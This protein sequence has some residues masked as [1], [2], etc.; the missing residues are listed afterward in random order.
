MSSDEISSLKRK[1]LSASDEVACIVGQ[2]RLAVKEPNKINSFMGMFKVLEKYYSIFE[3]AYDRLLGLADSSKSD[4][5]FPSTEE[6]ALKDNTRRYYYEANAIHYKLSSSE[7]AALQTS[8]QNVTISSDLNA[9][10]NDLPKIPLPKFDGQILNWPKFRD[11]FTSLVHNN[12]RITS[13]KKFFYLTSSL[14]GEA[15]SVLKHIPLEDKNY[16]LAWRT[17]T[18]AFENPRLIGAAYLNQILAF[19]PIQGKPTIE[20]IKT[21]LAKI[22]DNVAAF[23]LL[24]IEDETSFILLHLA[25]RCLDPTTRDQFE[26]AHKHEPFPTF[27]QLSKYLRERCLT[28]QLAD[29]ANVKFEESSSKSSFVKFNK[30]SPKSTLLASSD[31]SNSQ[32]SKPHFMQK[33][34]VV[35]HEGSHPL[36][37]CKKFVRSSVEQRLDFL[38]NWKGC[39]NCLSTTHQ[40]SHCS[41]KWSCRWC[42]AKHHSYLCKSLN[43]VDR[44]TSSNFCVEDDQINS[45][46][47]ERPSPSTSTSVCTHLSR[48][49]EMILG[50]IIAEIKDAR[51]IFQ[52]VRMVLDSGSHCSFLTQKCLRRLG[53]RITPSSVKVSSIG[54][55]Q[56]DGVKGEVFCDIRPVN[57]TQPILSTKALV[58]QNITNALPTIPVPS[59]I[60]KKYSQYPLA[61]PKFYETSPVEFLIGVDLFTD[62]W[63]GNAV[64]IDRQLPKLFPTVFGHVVMGS[65]SDNSPNVKVVPTLFTVTQDDDLTKGIAKFWEIEELPT[66][67][68]TNPDDQ[69]CEDHFINTHQRL[70]DGSYMVSLPFISSP[71]D[72]SSVSALSLRRFYNLETKFQRNPI[73]RNL[74]LE[75]MTDY[76]NLG[77]M[78]ITDDMPKYVIPH[79]S[80]LKEDRNKTKLRVVFDA[81]ARA[82]HGSLNDYLMTGP[83][84]QTD[85]R[86]VLLN[87]RSHK[88]VFVTDFVKMYRCIWVDP[89][90]RPYQCIYWR[91]SPDKS[92]DTYQCN[93][94][95]YGLTSSPYLAL[96]TVKQLCVDEGEAFPEAVRVLLRDTYIDDVA[97]GTNSLSD[98]IKLRDDLI[99]L[100]AKGNFTLSKWASNHP[101]LLEKIESSDKNEDPVSL[102]SK[103]DTTLKILGLQWNPDI[104]CFTYKFEP[105]RPVFTKRAILSNIA[106]IYDPLGFLS[107]FVITMKMIMQELWKLRIGWDQHIPDNLSKLWQS[108]ISDINI[109][110]TL[111]IPRYVFT[112]SKHQ[113]QIIG[114]SDAS[115]KAYCAAIYLKVI[116]STNTFTNLLV[117]KTKLAPLKTLSVPRLELLGALLLSK[118][119]SSIQPFIQILGNERLEDIFYTDSTIVLGWLATPPYLLKTFIANRVLEITNIIPYSLWC[120]VCT[121]HNP[122]DLGTRGLTPHQLINNQLWWT[123]P[124]WML[125]PASSWPRSV[126]PTPTDELPELKPVLC[127]TASN[128]T[129]SSFILAFIERFSSYPRLLRT[130]A[131]IKRLFYN[132]RKSNSPHV[133]PIQLCEIED[134]LIIFIKAVQLHYFFKGNFD[135]Q[136]PTMKRFLKLNPFLDNA[137]VLRAGGRLYHAQLPFNHKHPVLLPPDCHLSTLIVDH[138]HRIHLHPGPSL[139]QAIIQTEFWIPS[140]RRLV[141]KRIFMCV[142]CYKFRAKTLIPKMGDL[143][144]QRL[145]GERAFL[146]VGIDFA[147]PFSMK[148]SS[149]RNS[150]I[151]KAY[152]CLFICMASKALHLEAVSSLSTSAFLSTLDRFTAR[153]GVPADIYTD[154]G[155]TFI[156]ASKH[157]KELWEWFQKTSTQSEILDHCTVRH[158]HWHFNPPLASHFGGLWEA[159]VKSAKIYLKKAVG[160]SALTYEEFST[161]L[162]Q[163]EAILNSRPLCPL[164]SDP[165]EC[166]YLSP[167]HFLIG[168][169]L[170]SIPE[171]SLLDERLNTL[172]RWQLVKRMIEFFWR[173]WRI[174]YLSSLQSR[175]KW[176]KSSPSLTIGDLALLKDPNTPLMN[177]PMGR[178][179]EVHPGHDGVVRVVTIKTSKNTYKRP[180]TKLIPLIPANSPPMMAQ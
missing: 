140:L 152:M 115:E 12:D 177:W 155:T 15:E 5:T 123:G 13:I 38:K 17:L 87:F 31:S 69:I 168:E 131:R 26:V 171:P 82:D 64:S 61:D 129:R 92:V 81:S 154:C 138:F 101:K 50:T 71:P 63:R 90:D 109:L 94:V 151:S 146:R 173:R 107:P 103:E 106:K 125:F 32:S 176:N 96:R 19:K 144:S 148:F 65:F 95:T 180:V 79:H 80:I 120:H 117:A 104:D 108:L 53:L 160:D 121:D 67:S 156:A 22:C 77:H 56:F 158:I 75:F 88:W 55:S 111:R 1:L 85:I 41:S 25:L 165:A 7:P 3:E 114:F 44:P 157:L 139:L 135:N 175:V 21:F 159:G 134:A 84:L 122:S 6:K 126:I 142:K 73:L 136:E 147:G 47:N 2:G 40:S 23:K 48:R 10:S 93:T 116:S 150:P 118:L 11:T 62:I 46:V 60:W 179:I 68:I 52:P 28:L 39:R 18:G 127:V 33:S 97:T 91:S 124:S 172:D 29:G 174:E 145:K 161:L 51:G 141:R 45:T 35:C 102:S 24:G 76:L 37:G 98:A 66:T 59:H 162:A 58:V 132:A 70:P 36:V 149:R 83:K 74:Y 128:E 27:D 163:I 54:Q 89:K 130:F 30:F 143:P 14:V 8:S 57:K 113:Y 137:G 112:D 34:C 20:I 42:N 119:Y 105:I 178:V 164:S 86:D 16:S 153:R 78:N 133:G 170:L 166:E 167:G 9:H 4:L 72:L 99:T 110:S 43:T 49:S 169:P 100:L